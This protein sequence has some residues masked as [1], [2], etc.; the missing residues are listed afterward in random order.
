MLYP[1]LKSL[2]HIKDFILGRNLTNAK[3]VESHFPSYQPLKAIRKC[4]LTKDIM[5]KSFTNAMNVTEP[6]D[7]IPHLEDIIEFIL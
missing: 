2:K 4:I 7:T 3:N 1:V 5:E 6:V